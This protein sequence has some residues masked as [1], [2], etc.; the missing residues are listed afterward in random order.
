M[1]VD[2]ERTSEYRL[3]GQNLVHVDEVNSTRL[4]RGPLLLSL[5]ATRRGGTLDATRCPAVPAE[6]P[7]LAAVKAR[8]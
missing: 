6:V 4:R 1:T 8:T 7:G 3:S 5:A 2:C